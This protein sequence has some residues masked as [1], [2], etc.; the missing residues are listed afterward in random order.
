MPIYAI[1]DIHGQYDLLCRLLDKIEFSENSDQLWIIGDIVNRGPDSLKVCQLI[2][3]LKNSAISIL[4]NHDIHLIMVANTSS[5]FSN[6]YTFSDILMSPERNEI[7]DWIRHRPLLHRHGHVAMIHAG[8]IPEWTL[9]QAE[10]LAK[11]AEILFRSPNYQD[12]LPEL[13]G[14][15]PN[16]WSNDLTGIDRIRCIINVFTRLR[17][18][19]AD[20]TID[21][22]IKGEP[23][24][25][26][27][28]FMPWFDIEDRKTKD[29]LLITGHWSALGLY[30]KQNHLGIDTGACWGR[31]LTAVRLDDR[32]VFQVFR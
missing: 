31:A 18:C 29:D 9:D 8:I 24:Q 4:G 28:G 21:F 1:G 3:S 25:A 30:I 12:R 10:R 27:D 6:T 19:K 22:Q 5:I 11:E 17:F 7:V 16:R 32:K 14:N 23:D 2:R 15:H 26:R 20:G 13:Y